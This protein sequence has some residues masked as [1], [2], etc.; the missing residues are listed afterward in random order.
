MKK[1]CVRAECSVE[2]VTKD[3]RKK[4]CGRSCAAIENN[5]LYPKRYKNKV[6]DG[7]KKC[8]YCSYQLLGHQSYFCSKVCSG[9]YRT[10]KYL[11][12]WYCELNNGSQ[13][14]GLISR[15]IRDHL[16]EKANSRCQSPNCCV[17]GG[18]SVPN[19][20]I[21]RPILTIDHIDGNWKNNAPTNLIV[22]CYNCH[23]LT[24]TF[25]ALNAGNGA[26]LRGSARKLY[27]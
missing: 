5:T 22:L 8:R 23:T 4:Y 17:P 25:N 13:E 19:P 20:K 1:N 9:K 16:L 15:I 11:D 7:E 27:G 10:K 21:G 2:F 6:G 26:G 24:P 18:W 3:S 14:S 12:D